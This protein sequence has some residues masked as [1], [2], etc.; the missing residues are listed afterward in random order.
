[1]S[2]D[3]AKA[4]DVASIDWASWQPRDH[5]TLLFAITDGQVLL[6]RKKRGLGEGKINAPGGR[7]EPGETARQAAI[8]E[9]EEELCVRATGVTYAGEHHFQFRDGYS[10]HVAVFRATG[11]EGTPQETDEAIPLVVSVDAI[12]YEE[13]WADDPHW[14]P[15]LLAGERFCSWSIF[16]GDE[17]VDW[18]LEL[19]P[20]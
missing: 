19:Q 6:M 7:L 3:P 11:Y 17:M 8:R 9:V 20:G 16:D 1:M 5:A 13:M 10:M 2:D 15:H 14:I 4:P 12:P 18:R